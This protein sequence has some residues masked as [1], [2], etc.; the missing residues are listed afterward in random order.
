MRNH[1]DQK[2]R[3][4]KEAVSKR[5]PAVVIQFYQAKESGYPIP[6]PEERKM[7]MV[8]EAINDPLYSFRNHEGKIDETNKI[9]MQCLLELQV[10]ELFRYV[11]G[12]RK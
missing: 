2:F 4:W 7:G 12:I 5:L 11:K 8:I 9:A 1:F 3:N 10:E 6:S